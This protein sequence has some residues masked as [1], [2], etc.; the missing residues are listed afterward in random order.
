MIQDTSSWSIGLLWLAVIGFTTFGPHTLLVAQLPMLFGN[1]KNTAS[2][3]GFIDGIGYIGA[4][5]TGVF[6]GWL[7]DDFGW[8][9]AFYFW[10]FGAVLAGLFIFFSHR[11]QKSTQKVKKADAV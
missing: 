3:T 5:L 4:A 2:I 7:I 10:V 6:S 8:N 11:G 1:K 9:Y